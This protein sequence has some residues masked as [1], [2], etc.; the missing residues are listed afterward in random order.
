M[1]II[2]RNVI[3]SYID[4]P[5]ISIVITRPFPR[6]RILVNANENINA[7]GEPRKPG[8]GD[9]EILRLYVCMLLTVQVRNLPFRRYDNYLE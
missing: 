7:I 8:V 9:I 5:L 6:S 2:Q 4:P 3:P 1:P